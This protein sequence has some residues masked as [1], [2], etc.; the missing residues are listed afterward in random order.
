MKDYT[1]K[2]RVLKCVPY[3]ERISSDDLE[4]V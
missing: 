1:L 3:T 2:Y 4:A